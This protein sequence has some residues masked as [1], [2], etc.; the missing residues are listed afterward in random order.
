MSYRETRR[1]LLEERAYRELIYAEHDIS[2]WTTKSDIERLFNV[3]AEAY[4]FLVK[5]NNRSHLLAPAK[6]NIANLIRDWGDFIR[7]DEDEEP[8][9]PKFGDVVDKL[10]LAVLDP[11]EIATL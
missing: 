9:E 2:F 1:H 7:R 8:K 11:E 10:E 4:L 6:S 3:L 5:V